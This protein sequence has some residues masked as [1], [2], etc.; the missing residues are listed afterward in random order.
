MNVDVDELVYLFLKLL[1]ILCIFFFAMAIYFS[2]NMVKISVQLFLLKF[3]LDKATL[4]TEVHNEIQK[5][6]VSQ[7]FC[8]DFVTA[9]IA[10]QRNF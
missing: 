6:A 5:H 10:L 7:C 9:K 1:K 8:F 4:K 2:Y 3:S